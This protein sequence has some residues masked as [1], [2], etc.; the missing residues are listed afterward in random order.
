MN[1]LAVKGFE[2][3][4]SGFMFR[5]IRFLDINGDGHN[6][7]VNLED[8][9]RG[10]GWVEYK[11]GKEYVRW[12]LVKKHLEGIN[13]RSGVAKSVLDGNN[14]PTPAEKN[15]LIEWVT[16]STFFRL[17]FK[18]RNDM[19][20]SFQ[21]S[22]FDEILPAIDEYGAYMTE[23]K[24]NAF[25]EAIKKKERD[26]RIEI[27]V[28]SIASDLS[29]N[30]M[31]VNAFNER[32]DMKWPVK[33]FSQIGKILVGYA[34]LNEF[35]IG[36]SYKKIKDPTSRW[37]YVY[38]YSIE[39]WDAFLKSDE[40][41]DKIYKI[42]GMWPNSDVLDGK[43]FNADRLTCINEINMKTDFG[44]VSVDVANREIEF[45]SEKGNL[46]LEN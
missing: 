11:D 3:T 17:A 33:T 2:L 39:L 23:Q 24:A 32:L 19:A 18:A 43:K 14:P 20:K 15:G 13:F 12:N 30:W 16:K 7:L 22:V 41:Q 29:A 46:L 45:I 4:G 1:D 21:D 35:K 38:S 27:L 5:G 25:E 44:E 40:V 37:P 34:E 9:A 26:Y 42:T 6:V 36:E 28:L 8:I 10:F 31:T